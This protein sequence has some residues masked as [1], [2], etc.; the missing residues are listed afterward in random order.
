MTQFIEL[1]K[2]EERRLLNGPYGD[3]KI[4]GLGCNRFIVYCN[5]DAQLVL[6]RTKE[7]LLKVNRIFQE[8]I[9]ESHEWFSLLPEYFVYRCRPES[10]PEEDEREN[11]LYHKIIECISQESYENYKRLKSTLNNIESW[12]LLSWIFWFHENNRYWYWWDSYVHENSHIFVAVEVYTCPFPSLSLSWLF[13]G[14]GSCYVE[15]EPE[16]INDELG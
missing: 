6:K 10:L 2:N 3:E 7:V 13:R 8:R 5:N 4:G 9:P 15:C 12:S 1:L 16:G 11:I 14:C